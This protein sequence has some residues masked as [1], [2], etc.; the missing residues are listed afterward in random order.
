MLISMVLASILIRTSG[1]LPSTLIS[2]SISTSRRETW[3]K[4]NR[5]FSTPPSPPPSAGGSEP[6]SFY[7][8]IFETTSNPPVDDAF[9]STISEADPY[10]PTS[11]PEPPT[12]TFINNASDS[13]KSFLAASSSGTGSRDF[14]STQ[15]DSLL[16][17]TDEIYQMS[18]REFN[19]NSPAQLS[20]VLYGVKNG[21]STAKDSLEAM[22]GAGNPLA[23]KVLK[24]RSLKSSIKRQ[25]KQ[26]ERMSARRKLGS[27]ISA[28]PEANSPNMKDNFTSG[29]DPLLLI[30]ASAYIFRAYYAMPPLHR[31]DG[32]P[33]GAVL[34]F[35]NMLN[36]LVMERLLRGERPRLVMVFD[37][38][39][40]NFR[41]EIY[42][43][44]KANRPPCPID[45]VPQF[46]LIRALATA[47]GCQQI[48]A[49][50]YEADDVIATLSV[51]GV[52]EGV[53][54]NVV[55]S[56]KDLMQLVTRMGEE[57][58]VH[59][60]DPMKQIRVDENVVKEKWGVGPGKL[61]DVLALAGDSADN[62]PGIKGIGPKIASGLIEEYGDLEGLLEGCEGIKQNKRRELLMEGKEVAR[63]SRRL[64]ELVRDVP[65]DRMTG[66]EGMEV[67]QL[68]ME[69]LNEE[70]LLN[71][72]EEMGFK[73][74][75]KRMKNRFGIEGR[76]LEGATKTGYYKKK[77]GGGGGGKVV[78]EEFDNVPF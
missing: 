5:H 44:Y 63:L 40:P 26:E 19:L 2:R 18:G 51:R 22:A 71:F 12:S 67:K 68:R 15:R 3:R 1:Y 61:G 54:V 41:H 33:T 47:Y 14:L 45:L 28:P 31:S 46:P 66:M 59:L 70:R 64:V 32:T 76:R 30:D 75:R 17:V 55:S 25:E 58:S 56:D 48:E 4:L 60:I 49:P 10:N 62:V 72:Y 38:K 27:S 73:D 16:S 11:P 50:G 37:A 6:P 74:L 21:G 36:R 23:G 43:E 35:C 9:S 53:N 52:K 24:Y 13:T 78:P 34:G 8:A 65:E 42:N 29:R 77:G 20:E 39:G 69:E 57:P 7:D